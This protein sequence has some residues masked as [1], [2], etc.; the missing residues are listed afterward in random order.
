MIE[1]FETATVLLVVGMLTVFLILGLVVLSGH[2]LIVLVNK[3][4]DENLPSSGAIKR[5]NDGS[6]PNPAQLAAIVAAVDAATGGSGKI[7][8]IEKP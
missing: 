6:N 1:N 7:D 5:K 3:L 2:L 4:G 8:K